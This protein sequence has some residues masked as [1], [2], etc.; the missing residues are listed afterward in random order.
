MSNFYL[1][2]LGILTKKDYVGNTPGSDE[3][4]VVNQHR[5]VVLQ[6][7]MN[8]LLREVLLMPGKTVSFSVLSQK[9]ILQ[10]AVHVIYLN[11]NNDQKAG[12][13]T[14]YLSNIHIDSML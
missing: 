1:N 7:E 3:N 4:A 11:T 8:K 5:P 13:R 2:K 12:I 6:S 14:T 10:K 9:R